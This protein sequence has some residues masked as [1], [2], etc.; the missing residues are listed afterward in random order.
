[1]SNH[2]HCRDASPEIEK[3]VKLDRHFAFSEFCPRE[4]GQTK[5]GGC[6]IQRIGGVAQVYPEGVVG[7]KFS[8]FRYENM[9][10][11]LVNA[12][13]PDLVG[14]GQSIAGYFPPL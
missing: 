7:V 1:M 3:R 9:G 4:K 2:D 12:P 10:K 5:I 6:G 8:S 11:I 14:I 13:I